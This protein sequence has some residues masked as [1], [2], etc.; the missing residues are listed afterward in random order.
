MKKVARVLILVVLIG[1]LMGCMAGCDNSPGETNMPAATRLQATPKVP[2]PT[3]PNTLPPVNISTLSNTQA[4]T[5]LVTLEPDQHQTLPSNSPSMTSTSFADGTFYVMDHMLYGT[6]SLIPVRQELYEPIKPSIAGVPGPSFASAVMFSNYDEKIAY[7]HMVDEKEQLWISNLA[8]TKPK[9]VWQD[10]LDYLRID[11]QVYAD[12]KIRWG[13]HD[14]SLFL[15]YENTYLFISLKNSTTV[16]LA[17]ACEWVGV[18][19][20]TGLWALWCVTKEVPGKRYLVVEQ[21]GTNWISTSLPE[22]NC[23]NVVD[24]SFAPEQNKVLYA[25]KGG[26]MMLAEESGETRSI[27]FFYAPPLRDTTMRSLQWTPDGAK[28]FMYVENEEGSCPVNDRISMPCW[29]IVDADR[30]KLVWPEES[31]KILSDCEAILSPDGKWVAAN[32][33]DSSGLVDRFVE[34][35]SLLDNKGY[36]ISYWQVGAMYWAR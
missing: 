23:Q 35:R 11:P 29:V 18:S 14:N 7:L 3:A 13:P 26:R 28:L 8:L 1:L 6:Y 17:G 10:D 32:I 34:I 36:K 30:Y 31:Q 25:D 5:D 16:L 2:S 33:L 4:T 9:K 19:P 22:K 15:S 24:W 20:R 12:F 21:E 27:G